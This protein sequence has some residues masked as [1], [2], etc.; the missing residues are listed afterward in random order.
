MEQERLLCASLAGFFPF[1]GHALY[2]PTGDAPLIPELLPRERRLLLP[3]IWKGHHLG[4]LMLTGVGVRQTRRLLPHLPAIA[5]LCLGTVAREQAMHR[6]ASTGLLTENAL[7]S[8]LEMEAE[9]LRNALADPAADSASD[10]AD[11]SAGVSAGRDGRSAPLHRLC[12]GMVVLRWTDGAACARSLGHSFCET[13]MRLLAEACQTALTSDIQAGR[14]NDFEIGLLFL[15]SGRTACQRVAQKCLELMSA[16]RLEDPVTLVQVR[17]L[18][19]AGHALYPQDMQGTEMALAMYDQARKLRDRARLAADAAARKAAEPGAVPPV[20]ALPFAS[21]LRE[22]GTVISRDGPDRLTVSLGRVV[23]AAE[24]MRFHVHAPVTDTG[25]RAGLKGEIVLLQVND[26]DAVAELLSVED[27]AFLPEPGDTL[28]LNE[29]DPQRLA[30]GAEV[31]TTVQTSGSDTGGARI[32]NEMGVVTTPE[33]NSQGDDTGTVLYG[34]GE[35]L[36]RFSLERGQCARFVLALVRLVPKVGTD[37]AREAFLCRIPQIIASAAARMAAPVPRLAGRYGSQ[38]CMLFHPDAAGEACVPLYCALCDEARQQGLDAAAGLAP[39]PLLEYGRAEMEAC[40]LKALEYALWLPEPRVGLCNSTALTM[41]ADRRY[42]LGDIF[43]AIEEYKLALLAD[44]HAVTARNSLGVCLAALGR[45]EEALRHFRLALRH[46]SDARMRAKIAYNL[47]AVYQSLG[48][49]RMAAR[50][51]GRCLA[52]DPQHLYACL[53]LGQLSERRGRRTAARRFFERA[54]TIEDALHGGQG[55]ARRH[56]AGLAVRQR[57]DSEARELLHDALLRNPED[58][59][60]LLLL[61]ETYLDAGEDP[62]MAEMLARKSARLQDSGR[63]WHILARA[64]RALG[65]E[66]QARQAEARAAMP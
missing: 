36:R 42:S 33:Q 13:M 39:Y 11:D 8:R 34:H 51:Y 6:D 47:G 10:P 38:S 50:Q 44:E 45:R 54:A 3:L 7:L 18:V 25:R 22:G 17:P 1:S 2:F 62:A 40:A 5:A 53:R 30:S 37:A 15:A 31:R 20:T 29:Y 41:S 23:K 64:L 49:A 60:A 27:P 52:Y 24:G 55:A 35:F 26:T 46:A 65:K 14:L 58:A 21:L 66:Q 56:L 19:C 48:D 43:G 16:V 32:P 9:R 63:A 12:T 61:A 57:K 28:I 4:V 59:A